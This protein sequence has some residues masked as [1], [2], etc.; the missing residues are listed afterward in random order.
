M[1]RMFLPPAISGLDFWYL[2]PLLVSVSLVYAAT[3]HELIGPILVHAARFAIW[4]IVFMAVVFVVIYLVTGWVD[5][6]GA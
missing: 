2:L 3:R 1:T 5:P 6:A 4:M